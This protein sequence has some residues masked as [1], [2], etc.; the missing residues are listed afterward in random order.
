MWKDYELWENGSFRK[1]KKIRSSGTLSKERSGCVVG[2]Q[3][4][5]NSA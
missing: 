4:H 1:N 3:D 2:A 5:S